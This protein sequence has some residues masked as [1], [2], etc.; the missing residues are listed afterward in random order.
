VGG[1]LR[2]LQGKGSCG[3]GSACDGARR[4][5]ML[6]YSWLFACGMLLA[7]LTAVAQQQ[8]PQSG[9]AATAAPGEPPAMFHTRANLVLVDV[10]V[11][12]KGKPV[13]GLKAEDFQVLEDAKQQRIATF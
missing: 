10:V 5:V 6:R 3:D 8:Q 9:V 7:L 4:T 11:R 2:N 12:D 1:A 13:Q